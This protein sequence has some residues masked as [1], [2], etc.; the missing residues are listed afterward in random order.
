M[1]E[2]KGPAPLVGVKREFAVFEP[3]GDPAVEVDPNP[4]MLNP[5]VIF[6]WLFQSQAQTGPASAKAPHENTEPD[7]LGLARQAPA[8]LLSG[9]RCDSDH[10]LHLRNRIRDQVYPVWYH[11]TYNGLERQDRVIRTGEIFAKVEYYRLTYA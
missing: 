9:L 7:R 11:G 3:V 2:V 5:H 4:A 1:L 10:A 8:N 6:C